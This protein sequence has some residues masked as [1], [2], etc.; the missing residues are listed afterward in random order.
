ME[1]YLTKNDVDKK[2]KVS[3]GWK[4]QQS[5]NEYVY[6]FHLTR[7]P[8]I[9]KVLSSICIDSNRP[10][11]RNSEVIRVFAV[12]KNNISKDNYRIIKGLVKAE[13]VF[14][15]RSWGEDIEK[16]VYKVMRIAKKRYEKDMKRIK[17]EDTNF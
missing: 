10:K 4:T 8:I 12:L 6:D 7:Y 14:K 9:I 5:G 13:T 16:A 17:N 1:R 11:N 2:L 3:R 15:T